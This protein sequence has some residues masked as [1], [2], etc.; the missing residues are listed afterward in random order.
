MTSANTSNPPILKLR[1][2]FQ[3]HLSIPAEDLDVIDLVF[4]VLASHRI[5]GDPLWGMIIDASGGG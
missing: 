4:A 2:A 3:R 1:E 5:P